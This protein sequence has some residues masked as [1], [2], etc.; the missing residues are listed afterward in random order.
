MPAF[1]T[2]KRF[3]EEVIATLPPSFVKNIQKYKEA[4]Y[5]GTQGPDILFY[6][7][8][9]DKNPIKIKGMQLH[10]TAAE[11]FFLKQAKQL[12]EENNVIEKDGQYLPYSAYAAYIAG[13]LCHF[14][15]DVCAHPHVYEKEAT[16][17]A[18][19]RIESELDKYLLRKDGFPIRGYN[20]AGMITDKNGSWEA[21]VKTLE[22]SKMQAKRA[23]RTIRYINGWFSAKH[24]C[25]HKFAHSVL[26]I[27]GV[28]GKFGEMFLH[29]EDEPT[30]SEWN[31][32][33]YQDYL[34]AIPQ[35]AAL[36]EEYFSNLPTIVQ[37]GKLH[38]FFRNN[39][40]GGTL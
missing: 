12:L 11:N 22:V 23:I 39:Y 38:E 9:L 19:G 31:E 2:H 6:H 5:L 40:T 30:C 32:V 33:L 24:E 20:T 17:I 10:L 29:N 18:H 34:S 21:C 4:F 35:A 3:G 1:Y 13:F 15:L 25:F 16:G 8:P 26:K 7:R 37:N 28:D 36:M 14:T 27:L